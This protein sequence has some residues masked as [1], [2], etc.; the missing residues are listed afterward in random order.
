M[1][2]YVFWTLVALLPSLLTVAW[3]LWQ[4]DNAENTS[5]HEVDHIF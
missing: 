4:A 3:M 5:D 2:P 1:G